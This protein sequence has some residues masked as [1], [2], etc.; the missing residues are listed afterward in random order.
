VYV[1][2]KKGLVYKDIQFRLKREKP[3]ETTR[4]LVPRQFGRGRKEERK[5]GGVVFVLLWR[6]EAKTGRRRM[7]M[8]MTDFLLRLHPGCRVG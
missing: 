4:R 5:K 6:T 2:D 1:S 3:N 8:M 7:M